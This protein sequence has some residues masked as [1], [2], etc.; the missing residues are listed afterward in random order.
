M[1]QGRVGAPRK[2]QELMRL[3]WRHVPTALRE[4][5]KNLPS[6]VGIHG[7]ALQAVTSRQGSQHQQEEGPTRKSGLTSPN[8]ES[9]V[10]RP[11]QCQPLRRTGL[12]DGTVL[13]E[14]MCLVLLRLQL[15]RHVKASLTQ[16]T[17]TSS[18]TLK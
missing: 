6:D 7:L 1:P 17:T 2:T 15:L 14:M 3:S 8:G 4:H 10:V 11:C 12:S 18:T 13:I 16:R 9:L 5:I